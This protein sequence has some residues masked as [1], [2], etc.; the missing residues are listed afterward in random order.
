MP[1]QLTVTVTFIIDDVSQM[2]LAH[3]LRRPSVT[4]E[5]VEQFIRQAS[6]DALVGAIME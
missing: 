5:E 3:H 6:T 1:G 4:P 2:A